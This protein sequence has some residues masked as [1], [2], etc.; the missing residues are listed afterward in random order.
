MTDTRHDADKITQKK[1]TMTKWGKP[2]N[3]DIWTWLRTADVMKIASSAAAA[4]SLKPNY[5]KWHGGEAVEKINVAAGFLFLRVLVA[6]AVAS[7]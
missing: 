6:P 3:R 7:Q 4:A 2:E 5:I 1:N